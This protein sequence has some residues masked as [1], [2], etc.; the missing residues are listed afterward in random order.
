MGRPAFCRSSDWDETIFCDKLHLEIQ[1]AHDAEK[2][3]RAGLDEALLDS[4]DV[5]LCSVDFFG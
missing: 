3:A 5:G 2:E 4:G 1:G